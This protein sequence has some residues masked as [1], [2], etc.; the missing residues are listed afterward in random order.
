MKPTVGL[1]LAALLLAPTSVA[2]DS[3]PQVVLATPGGAGG[4]I[5]RFTIRFS[6]AMV[7]L[8]YPRAAAP[9][10]VTCSVGG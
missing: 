10:S 3:S 4:T 2:S 8:G 1:A 9:I 6:Q 7:P 5:E